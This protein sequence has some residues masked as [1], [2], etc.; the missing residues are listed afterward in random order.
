[1]KIYRSILLFSLTIL[2]SCND[3][4]NKT[5]LRN[6]NLQNDTTMSVNEIKKQIKLQER[7]ETEEKEFENP[8][9]LN[10]IDLELASRIILKDL[11]SKGYNKISEEN[12][13]KK[14]KLIFKI[15]LSQKCDDFHIN[16]DFITLF[17]FKMDGKMDTLI[18]NQYDL[19]SYTQN[20]FISVK[21]YFI[22]NMFL[23]K[24]IISIRKDDTFQL[25]VPQNVI[26][27]N[28]FLFN[29]NKSSLAWLKLNDQYFLE[30]LVKTFG[31]VGDPDLL[32]WV[33]DKNLNNDEFDKIL[34]TKT[35]DNKYVFHKEIFEIMNQAD[36]SNKEKYIAFL[37]EHFPQVDKNNFSDETKIQA[38]Y[39]YYSTKLSGSVKAYDMYAFFPRL[40]DEESEQEFK[41]NN[42]Y[43]LTD[44]E[45]I[46]DETRY[47]GVGPAE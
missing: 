22:L 18:E 16:K 40:N 34:F 6:P 15:N 43:D 30:S 39:C 1:M 9:N 33:L 13:N 10:L 44:F 11:K 38:L 41:K 46:Y 19:F 23:L 37:K 4:N 17:G 27:R 25:N 14:I 45:E 3:K 31:Y 47:G 2:I 29:D 5:Q 7:V 24:D 35:C 21:D 42:Y 20:N 36:N 12:F 32:K 28:K 26:E 8:Y